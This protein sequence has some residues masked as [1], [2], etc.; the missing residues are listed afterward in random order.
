MTYRQRTPDPRWW[1]A[2]VGVFLCL[3]A[4]TTLTVL[5][6]SLPLLNLTLILSTII[7]L[8]LF[9]DIR[10][11]RK[12]QA[13]WN[14]NWVYYIVGSAILILPIFPIYAY[15]RYQLLADQI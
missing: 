8:P 13:S 6:H 14:P 10:A 1:Y 2:T 5:R 7:L 15:R 9:I 11:I 12:S 3:I 4:S